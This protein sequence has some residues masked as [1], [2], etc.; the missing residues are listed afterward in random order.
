L[1]LIERKENQGHKQTDT[2]TAGGDQLLKIK[3]PT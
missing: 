3:Q 1:Q 2:Y